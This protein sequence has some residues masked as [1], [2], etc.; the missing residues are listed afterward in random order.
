[1]T[2]LGD[3]YQAFYRARDH[4]LKV[5]YASPQSWDYYGSLSAHDFLER[6]TTNREYI[7]YEPSIRSLDAARTA[8]MVFLIA[9]EQ[10]LDQAMIWKLSNA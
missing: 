9:R 5:A 4:W 1:M 8:A 6:T 10:G 2:K 3:V 7:Q